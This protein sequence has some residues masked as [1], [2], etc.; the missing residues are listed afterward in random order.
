MVRADVEPTGEQLLGLRNVEPIR[1][2]DPTPGQPAVPEE[3]LEGGEVEAVNDTG[4]EIEGEQLVLFLSASSDDRVVVQ[5]AHD[6]S[7]DTAAGALGEVEA[8][9]GMTVAATLE[10]LREHT[11]ETSRLD[12][13]IAAVEEEQADPHKTSN[14]LHHCEVDGGS[15]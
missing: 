13:L 1:R 11:G 7:A 15:R 2:L 3:R 12:A 14:D 8:T 4:A 9:S 5:Y 6:P 10:C